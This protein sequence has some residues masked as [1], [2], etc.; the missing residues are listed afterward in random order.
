MTSRDTAGAHRFTAAPRGLVS[1]L[2]RVDTMEKPIPLSPPRARSHSSL[3]RCP[4]PHPTK[5]QCRH[6][7]RCRPPPLEPDHRLIP[8]HRS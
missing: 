4:T 2:S 5:A 3:S 1:I 8:H 6:V 7:G